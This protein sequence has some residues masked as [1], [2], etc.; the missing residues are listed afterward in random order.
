MP[1]GRG[2][3]LEETAQRGEEKSPCA[4][5][6]ALQASVFT[7]ANAANNGFAVRTK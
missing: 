4:S 3:F 7:S 2:V 6:S 5:A 1:R